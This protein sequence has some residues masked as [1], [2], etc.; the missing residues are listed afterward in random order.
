MPLQCLMLSLMCSWDTEK[1]FPY[2]FWVQSVR[3]VWLATV[4]HRVC[5]S[6][7]LHWLFIAR[8]IR[9]N[10][11]LIFV[12]QFRNDYQKPYHLFFNSVVPCLNLIH[13]IAFVVITTADNCLSFSMKTLLDGKVEGPS[14]IMIRYHSGSYDSVLDHREKKRE[15]REVSSVN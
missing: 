5:F 14:V 7:L 6:I 3:A 11:R 1:K 15:E 13:S 10:W 12:V 9:I 4:S 2:Y 8:D